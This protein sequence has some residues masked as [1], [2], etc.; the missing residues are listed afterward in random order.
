MSRIKMNGQIS[1]PITETLGVKQGNVKSS[2]HYNVYN[3][4]VLDTL[5]D[6]NLGVWIGPVN[7]GVSGV[8]DDD[9]LMSD[10]PIKLQGLLDIAEHSGNI[11]RIRHGASKTKIT[12]S[13]S[14]IDRQFYKDTTPWTMGG[15]HIKVT[16]DNEHSDLS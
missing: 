3:G 13:G 2:D 8:A 9:F 5:E 6:A 16:E 11:Y 15:E 12:V 14:E 1:R 4:P 7:T 10:D